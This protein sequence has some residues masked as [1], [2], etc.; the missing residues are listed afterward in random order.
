MT[1]SCCK[2]YYVVV[3]DVPVIRTQPV[4]NGGG[5]RDSDCFSVLATVEPASGLTYEW[6]VKKGS[7]GFVTMNVGRT[8]RLQPMLR[9][10]CS[11]YERL[12][13]PVHGHKQQVYATSA[14]TFEAT[15]MT[16]TDTEALD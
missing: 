5:R 1:S 8:Q 15:L 7:G 6:K 2:T 16:V 3:P 9:F 11:G 12:E 10:T 4:D 13:I 14:T